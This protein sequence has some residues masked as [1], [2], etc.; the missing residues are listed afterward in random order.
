MNLNLSLKT[1]QNAHKVAFVMQQYPEKTLP[2]MI[3]LLAMP[4]IDI[5]AALWAAEDLG[6]I[7]TPDKKTG[8]MK[9]LKE[10]DEWDFGPEVDNLR[11][12]IVYC[13][14]VLARRKTDLEEFFISKWT[15]GYAVIDVLVAMKSLLVQGKVGEYEVQD[16]RRDEKGNLMFAEDEN[17]P[18]MDTYIFYTLPQYVKYQW[19]RKSFKELPNKEV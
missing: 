13:L 14:E 6:Y 10:P 11:R 15:S 7:A 5:N 8:A 17:T 4:A 3:D 12:S 19:G 16:Q 2:H 1:M 18:Q 9:F